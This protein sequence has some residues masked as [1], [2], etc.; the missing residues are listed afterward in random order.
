VFWYHQ[1]VEFGT[2]VDSGY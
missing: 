1:H 2:H